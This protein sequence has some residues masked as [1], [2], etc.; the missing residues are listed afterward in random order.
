MERRCP[1]RTGCPRERANARRVS[2]AGNGLFAKAIA[3]PVADVLGQLPSLEHV[4][5]VTRNTAAAMTTVGRY[6]APQ[7]AGAPLVVETGRMCLRVHPESLGMTLFAE[8]VAAHRKPVSLHFFDRDG[9]VLHETY[10]TSIDEDSK[11]DMLISG[12]AGGEAEARS[13]AAPAPGSWTWQPQLLSPLAGLH[14]D[15]GFHVDSILGDNGIARRASL[16]VWGEG[17]A[18]QIDV[19]DLVGLFTLLKEAWMPLGIAVGNLGLVQYHQ[20]EI[21]GVKRSGNLVQISSK[22]SNVTI[23]LDDIEEAWITHVEAGG[24]REHILELYDWRCHCIAQFKDADDGDENLS[25]FWRQILSTL[26]RLRAVS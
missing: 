16:P 15:A 11:L 25:I 21:D 17:S 5:S 7:R 24:R 3:L 18:W 23:S 1:R 12:R 19:S 6:A 4:I 14:A 10:L 8:P 13:G 20:G 26:P 22:H 9:I 2:T